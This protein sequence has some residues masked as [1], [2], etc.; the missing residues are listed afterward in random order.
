[1]GPGRAGMTRLRNWPRSTL[2]VTLG[3]AFSLLPTIG[4][5]LA[6]LLLIGQPFQMRRSDSIWALAATASGLPAFINYGLSGVVLGAGPIVAAWLVY[7]AF[8][9]LPT[10]QDTGQFR[11]F[12]IG[13]L[14]GLAL[15]VFLGW[16]QNANL[17]FAY[18][19]AAQAISWETNPT[20]YGHTVLV[21]GMTI[22]LLVPFVRIRIGALALAAFGVLVSGSR[23]AGLAWL[24]F[25]L[26]LPAV[27]PSMHLARRIPRY[28]G[29]IA[30]LLVVLS[31]IGTLLGWG[32]AGF[33]VDVVPLPTSEHNLIQSSEFPDNAVWRDYGVTLS[34]SDVALADQLLTRVTVTKSEPEAWVRLQQVVDVESGQP[35]V[36]SAWMHA[37]D[38]SVHYGIQGW[39]E[40]R[41]GKTFSAVGTQADGG[42]S[43][44]ASAPAR[45]LDS[46]TSETYGDWQRNWFSF[47]YE[48]D[49]SPV[50]M[51]IGLAPD[52]RT[53]AGTA[54]EFA[55][56]QLERGEAPTDYVPG[57]ATRGIS[58]GAGRLP[59]WSAAW[60]GFTE[61][62]LI[63]KRESFPFYYASQS[64]QRVR[65]QEPPAHAHNQYLNVLYERGLIGFIGLTL[66]I[67]A[68]AW[69]AINRRDLPSLLL[70]SVVLLAN[71]FDTTLFYGGVLYPLAAVLGWRATTLG[72]QTEREQQR[73]A[74]FLNSA[75]LAL[76]SLAAPLL[77]A[78]LVALTGGL[79]NMAGTGEFTVPTFLSRPEFYYAC[80]LWPAFAWRE[81][82]FPGYGVSAPQQL[83][84]QVTA[85]VLAALVFAVVASQFPVGIEISFLQVLTISFLAMGFMPILHALMRRVLVRTGIWGEEVVILGAGQGGRRTTQA[86]V[87]NRLNGLNP[88]AIFDDNADKHG[89]TI[90]GIPVIGPLDDAV[91]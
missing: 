40:L 22:A 49:Q 81:G 10:T 50:Q 83:R 89:T 75:G 59:F 44:T 12:S 20:L 32:R 38:E 63:G 2:A 88:I 4:P 16:L 68:L 61:S 77:A 31:G 37:D 51:V 27:D 70:L 42:W 9:Q 62:P 26:I 47:I 54:A 67:L 60:Q 56:F 36:A 43:D 86:L 29:L 53:V 25:A 79:A 66:F 11:F 28:Y 24:V 5:F 78:G 30:L 19:T 84:R 45:I 91:N 55:G 21:L 13:L 90:A 65:I 80:L 57:S 8:S 74:R 73:L 48:G 46:G 85:S 72:H 18:R 3:L 33:L 82:L 14:I 71:F 17:S 39:A 76:A 6:V 15:T 41:N 35:Y 34:S 69:P 7:R 64:G 87:A 58:L 23:E 52:N 1:M